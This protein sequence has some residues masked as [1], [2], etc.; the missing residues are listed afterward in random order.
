MPK[1]PKY[2]QIQAKYPIAP[3]VIM[4]KNTKQPIA[5]PARDCECDKIVIP[6][7]ARPSIPKINTIKSVPVPATPSAEDF[8]YEQAKHYYNKKHL[9]L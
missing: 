5:P 6:I 2:G 7:Q 3:P 1:Q 8:K 4:K 9:S